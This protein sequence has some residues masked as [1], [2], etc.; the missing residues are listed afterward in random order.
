MKTKTFKC[1]NTIL[2]I[3]N[4]RKWLKSFHQSAVPVDEFVA[5]S[6][7]PSTDNHRKASYPKTQQRDHPDGSWNQICDQNRRKNDAFTLSA[8]LPTNK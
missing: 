7:S 2:A 4:Y 6:K 3:V 8:T 5:C 1:Y